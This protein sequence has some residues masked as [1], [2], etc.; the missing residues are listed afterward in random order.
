MNKSELK[1]MLVRKN[2]NVEQLASKLGINIATCYRK[3][4]DATFTIKEVNEIVKMFDL[5][6]YETLTIFFNKKVA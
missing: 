1:A 4:N 3:I 5:S 2:V 6:D